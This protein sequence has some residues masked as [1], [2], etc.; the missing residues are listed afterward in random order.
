[1]EAELEES[2]EKTMRK[3]V[4]VASYIKEAHIEAERRASEKKVVNEE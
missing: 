2:P 1:M 4:S 3:D